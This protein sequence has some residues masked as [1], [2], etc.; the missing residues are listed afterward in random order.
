[1]TRS[2]GTEGSLTVAQLKTY[3][4]NW[5]IDMETNP[6]SL[7]IID[8]LEEIPAVRGDHPRKV[9]DLIQTVEK[10]LSDLTELGNTSAIKNPL[11]IRSIESKLPDAA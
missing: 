6:Q 9:I 10:A 7:E 4:G 8:E 11:V 1:M 5:R 3:S 2:L